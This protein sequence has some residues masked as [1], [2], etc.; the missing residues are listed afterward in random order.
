MSFRLGFSVSVH[1]VSD[2]R[3]HAQLP[4]AVDPAKLPLLVCLQFCGVDP[5]TIPRVL[6]FRVWVYNT[7]QALRKA[8]S[9][10]IPAG[11]GPSSSLH[12]AKRPLKLP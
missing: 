12:A 8:S 2:Q 3:Q 9:R 5:T 1:C 4:T 10:R 11:I 6:G 7:R